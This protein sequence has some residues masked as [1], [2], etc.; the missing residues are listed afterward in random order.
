M[1]VKTA[2]SPA[3]NKLLLTEGRISNLSLRGR[4]PQRNDHSLIA[5]RLFYRWEAR[6]VKGKMFGMAAFADVSCYHKS[7]RPVPC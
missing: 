5:L 6:S 1:Q 2:R 7:T 4:S 3:Q